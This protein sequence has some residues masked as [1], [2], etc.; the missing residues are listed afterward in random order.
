MKENNML[1]GKFKG[2]KKKGNGAKNK[3]IEYYVSSS[4]RYKLVN[5]QNYIIVMPLWE[6]WIRLMLILISWFIIFH[7]NW[8]KINGIDQFITP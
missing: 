1:W 7:I 3:I 8:D 6:Y 4:N 2:W 5:S